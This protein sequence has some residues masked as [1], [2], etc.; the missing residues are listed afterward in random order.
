VEAMCRFESRFAVNYSKLQLAS[1]LA[2][3]CLLC[4]WLACGWYMLLE[5]EMNIECVY[6]VRDAE[7][8]NH[9]RVEQ[10]GGLRSYYRYRRPSHLHRL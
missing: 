1:Y 10:M 4:H 3:L 9:E 6:Q 5:V 7:W 2:L 8:R